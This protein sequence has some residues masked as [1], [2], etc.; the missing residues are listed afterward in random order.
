MTWSG[1][2][3]LFGCCSLTSQDP[4]EGTAMLRYL[5][6]GGYVTDEFATPTQPEFDCPLADDAELPVISVP[7]LFGTYLRYGAYVCSPPALDRTFGTIDFLVCLDTAKLDARV[8][9]LFFSNFGAAL[10]AERD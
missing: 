2:R 3:Y 9:S 5:E 7:K 8:K 4:R 6:Q 10:G 1:N